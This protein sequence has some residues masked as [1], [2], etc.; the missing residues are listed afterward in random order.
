MPLP[1]RFSGGSVS[2][3][4]TA[5][6]AIIAMPRMKRARKTPRHCVTDISAPPME[7]ARMGATPMTNISRESTTAASCPVNRSRTIAIAITPVAAAP[8]P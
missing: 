5:A 4:D 8:K 6:S 7:G 2:G 3:S 1:D